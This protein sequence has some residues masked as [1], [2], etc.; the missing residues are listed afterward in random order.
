MF[1]NRQLIRKVSRGGFPFPRHYACHCL[2]QARP[3]AS[4]SECRHRIDKKHHVCL[5]TF[6][7]Q[8]KPSYYNSRQRHHPSVCIGVAV[9][10]V[11][12]T[13][14]RFGFACS[15]RFGLAFVCIGDVSFVWMGRQ[16]GRTHRAEKSYT[17][18][19]LHSFV[20]LDHMWWPLPRG[21]LDPTFQNPGPEIMDCGGRNGPFPPSSPRGMVG[22][23][24]PPP[25]P[26]RLLGGKGPFRPPN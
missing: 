8:S 22:F 9:R 4:E 12:A 11:A 16:I 5:L 3:G 20:G 1:P 18:K 15:R 21:P 17:P 25:F 10:H 26:G 19:S 13:S 7:R 24:P 6:V 2:V 23:P 14:I